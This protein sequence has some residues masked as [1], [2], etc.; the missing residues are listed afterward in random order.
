MRT[1]WHILSLLLWLGVMGL[2]LA[3][4]SMAQADDEAAATA[5][6]DDTA[7]E[8]A[9]PTE[10]ESGTVVPKPEN[11]LTYALNSFGLFL[12]AV[13][14]LFMQAGFAMV[15]SGFNAA[16]NTVNI[17]YKNAM[18]LSVGVLLFFIVGF[19]LMYPGSFGEDKVTNAYFSFGGTGIYEASVDQAYSPQ[20]D[21]FF[22]AVFAATAATIV[23]GA[24]AGRMQFKSYLVFSA[25]LTGLVYPISGYW[26]WGGG[27]LDAMGFQDFAGSA[28]VHAVGGFAGLAGAIL[29]GP[30]IGRFVNGKSVAIPGHNLTFAALGV[31]ILWVGWYG[32]N[33]GS[34]LAFASVA[35]ADAVVKIAVNTTLAAAAGV[36]LA[37]MT[38]WI[39]FGKPDLS[40]GLN[41]ALAGLVGITAC[42]DCM[43]NVMSIVVGA[44][45]GVLVVGGIILLDKLKIDDPVGAFPVHGLCGIWGCLAIGILPNTHL[46]AGTTTFGVQLLATAAICA[47]AFGTMFVLF[48]ALKMLGVLRV[49]AQDEQEGLDISE[50]GM[51]AYPAQS[52]VDHIPSTP[53]AKEHELVG[54]K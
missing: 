39:L 50:H 53:S 11:E 24:V 3:P 10:E 15:E 6:A 52:I 28:V 23:S 38:G 2:V 19:G 35:D 5:A 37:T 32:F 51:H 17:L 18:D 31:F 49:N 16:K 44:V 46:A 4:A 34:Q 40:L 27:W 47:W 43:S 20:V 48:F 36:V 14:V 29:L 41:G 26:K 25:V 33:P 21:W 7:A 13:L 45:A 8:D 9:A 30:R 54:S 12:C 22:Q 1:H 42:C